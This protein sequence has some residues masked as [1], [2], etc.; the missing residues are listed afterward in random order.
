MDGAS[1]P[2]VFRGL[3]GQPLES[4]FQVPSLIHDA[5][6]DDRARRVL[7]DVIFYY[8][9]RQNR[10]PRWKALL[11]YSAVRLGGHVYYAAEY[12]RFWRRVKRLLERA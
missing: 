2:Q 11:M 10:V 1:I 9:L 12:S 7:Q 3:I 4:D 5:G 6:Y 8:L